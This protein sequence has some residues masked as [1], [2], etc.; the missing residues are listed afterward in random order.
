MEPKTIYIEDKQP[1]LK[2]IQKMVGGYLEFVWDN[3]VV[4]VICNEEG[5]LQG[6]PINR[7]ATEIWAELLFE[8]GNSIISRM[9]DCLVGDV[10]IL[11]GN[12]RLN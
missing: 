2:E 1:T 6:L 12:A 4:Q 11:K 3:G 5:K 7:E 8:G 9:S 10:V